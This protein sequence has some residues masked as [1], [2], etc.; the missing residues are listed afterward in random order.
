MDEIGIFF[1]KNFSNFVWLGVFI[2]SMLPVLEGKIALSVA[3]NE[4]LLGQNVMTP[5][6]AI[7]TSF[8]AGIFL[9]IF[10]IYFFKSLCEYLSKFPFFT[11]FNQKIQ[12]FIAKKSEKL[13]NK[14]KI[15]LW[16]FVFV[17]IPLPLTG[18]YTSSMIS[19][20]LS[21]NSKK[22]L[23]AIN[24]GNICSLTI[25]YFLTLIF[26]E[27]TTIILV[28]TFAITILII[29]LIKIFKTKNKVGFLKD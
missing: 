19:S 1:A 20:F 13:K 22:S 18:V 27:Y 12:N 6:L 14:S 3:L 5:P 21:L 25:I 11:K 4:M 16:L 7:A 26:K 29:Y 8:I 10:L 24:L 9:S 15:F 2:F 28:S 17:A 23:I